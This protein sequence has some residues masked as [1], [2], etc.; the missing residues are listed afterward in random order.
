MRYRKLDSAGDYTLGSGADFLANSPETVAQAV[1]TRLEL[2]AGEWFINTADGTPWPDDM[3]GK[4]FQRSNPDSAIKS[5]IL[6]TPGVTE[7]VEYSSAFDGETRKFSVTAKIN[8]AYGP[9]AIMEIL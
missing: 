8:T 3:L 7:L 2:W 5:R 4:R 6:G 9:A 1:R